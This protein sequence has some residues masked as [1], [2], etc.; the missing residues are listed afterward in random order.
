MQKKNQVDIQMTLE[1]LHKKSEYLLE[2][3]EVY[4][5]ITSDDL[6][7]RPVYSRRNGLLFQEVSR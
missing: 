5:K 1:K 3:S 7:K 2:L 4:R 6:K